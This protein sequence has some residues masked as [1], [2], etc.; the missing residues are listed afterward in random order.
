MLELSQWGTRPLNAV[1]LGSQTVTLE[2][3]LLGVF[4]ETALPLTGFRERLPLVS[5]GDS[6]DVIAF[7]MARLNH[8]ST[9]KRTI[10]A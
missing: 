9:I 5:A 1:R 4:G 7:V 6:G 3:I 2:P 10:T 8:I